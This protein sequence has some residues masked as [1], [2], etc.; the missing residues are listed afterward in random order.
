MIMA[1]TRHRQQL[2]TVLVEM[3]WWK[4]GNIGYI[5]PA[6]PVTMRNGRPHYLIYWD[7]SGFKNEY[8][9][10]SLVRKMEDVSK[11]KCTRYSPDEVRISPEQRMA[12]KGFRKDRALGRR[13]FEASSSPRRRIVEED[14]TLELSVDPFAE[15]PPEEKLQAKALPIERLEAA[16]KEAPK[17][18]SEERLR[19]QA[20]QRRAQEVQRRSPHVDEEDVQASKP[21]VE[22]S[23][24]L[25][26]LQEKSKTSSRRRCL[27]PEETLQAKA[28]LIERL[29]AAK[30]E[31]PKSLPEERLRL[32]AAQRRAQA[33]Q[34]RSPQVG[35]EDVQASKPLAEGRQKYPQLQE[36]YKQSSRRR[37]LIPEETLQAKA[38][39]IERLEAAKKEA[40][41][42][43]P[44][45]RLRLQ[46]VQRRAQ[47]VQRRSLQAPKPPP[48]E[49]LRLQAVQR[50]AQAAQGR[51][52]HV[53]EEDVQASKPL[54]EGRKKYSTLQE[55]SVDEDIQAS[56]PLVEGSQKSPGLLE[57]SKQSSR[58]RHL[59]TEETLQAKALPIERLEAAKKEAPKPP[60]EER[61]R[62][63]AAQRRAQAVQEDHCK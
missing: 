11:S 7:N 4:C 40:H 10:C 9:E 29:E 17:P 12:L 36:K 31:A 60:L 26:Q 5:D 46:A 18:L 50:R 20:A 49:K 48:E 22:G 52:P 63:Q 3:P 1:P 6:E 45:E 41:K 32:Q 57:K 27:I 19:L 58:R 15:V 8:V 37:C 34:R 47:A 44:E 30:K 55:K 13:L 25:P 61:L 21:L 56:K 39:L 54:V 35:E 62:L 53:G 59:I 23:Q 28:P 38:P 16:K 14:D 51:S 42:P 2:E 33:V 43:L 24:K